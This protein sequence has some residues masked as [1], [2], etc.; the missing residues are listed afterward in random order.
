[1]NPVTAWLSSSFAQKILRQKIH[2]HGKTDQSDRGRVRDATEHN[3][4]GEQN[5]KN[6]ATSRKETHKTLRANKRFAENT[7][8]CELCKE[9]RG[10][11]EE[12]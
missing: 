4:K 3:Q 12:L 2:L 11:R 9:I 10:I 6:K 7:Q 8:K 1:M 5:Q